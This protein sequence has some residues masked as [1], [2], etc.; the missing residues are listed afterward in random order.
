M[1]SKSSFKRSQTLAS[2]LV[3]VVSPATHA[4]HANV[5]CADCLE[6][7]TTPS[8]CHMQARMNTR[9]ESSCAIVELSW[10][11]AA[12]SAV[13]SSHLLTRHQ[14]ADLGLPTWLLR[15]AQSLNLALPR[16]HTFLQHVYAVPRKALMTV[17]EIAE[18][19]VE[20]ALLFES[21]NSF[22]KICE[23]LNVSMPKVCGF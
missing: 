4:C 5:A 20:V 6:W 18:C 3:A 7:N 8:S 19:K 22:A 14:F 15:L 2:A 11:I 16:H 13:V 17:E 1:L 21:L 9:R 23:L 10:S 12:A